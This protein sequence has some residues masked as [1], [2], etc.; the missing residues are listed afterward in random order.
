M[1][2]SDKINPKKIIKNIKKY[3]MLNQ[4]KRVN[5]LKICSH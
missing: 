4:M 2:T 3:L 1:N 5:I